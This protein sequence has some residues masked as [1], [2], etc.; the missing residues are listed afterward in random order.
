MGALT[1]PFHEKQLEYI[2]HATRRWN[3]KTGATRSGKTFMDYAYVIPRRVTRLR[4]DGLI[5]LMGNTQASLS[6]NVLEPMRGIWG[7]GLVGPVRAGGT[8]NLFGRKAFVLGADKRNRVAALQ[9]SGIE[10]CYG[11]E[12]ATW[13]E[14]VFT[15]LKS[16]LD[17]PDSVFDGT[18]NPEHPGHWLKQFLDSGADLYHQHYTIDDNPSLPR[19]FVAALKRE[20]RGTVYYDRYIL[21]QWKRAEGAVY[22]LFADD[23]EA[24][25]LDR[26]PENIAFCTAGIDFG[27]HRSATALNLTGFERGM[28]GV[29]T[30]DEAYYDAKRIREGMGEGRESLTPGELEAAVVG[31]LRRNGGRGYRIIALYADGAE[32]VLMAGIR[33]AL[34]RA[35]IGIPVYNAR[36]GPIMNRVRFYNALMSGG[37]YHVMRHCVHTIRAFEE[38]VFDK[39][40]LEDRRLDDG[41]TNIDSLDAQEY[42]TEA[43]QEQMSAVR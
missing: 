7:S 14:D 32:Q 37:K 10:Y 34:A 36:K 18:C 11:D 23:P 26:P 2:Q 38:A 6:R 25:L 3:F 31:F 13:A 42:S 33:A 8:V 9:G 5:V 28:R 30:L 27:G 24:F 43:Y 22:R 29:V 40:A 19:E 12:V 21:G 16:R 20:Y 17:K 15:M 41:S 4:G 1:V 35:G 39:R